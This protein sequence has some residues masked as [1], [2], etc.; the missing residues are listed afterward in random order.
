MKIK[1]FIG[2]I[3]ESNGYVLYQQEGGACY[4][5]DPGYS[6][7]TFINYIEEMKL[8]LKGILLTHHH[9]DHVGAVRKLSAHF[10]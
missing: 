7:K 4:V 3:L 6:S 8:D 1:R 9:T 2:G 10:G 5:V